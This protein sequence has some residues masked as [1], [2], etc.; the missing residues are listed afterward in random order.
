MTL[1]V[2]A[3]LAPLPG[4]NLRAEMPL[5]DTALLA[6]VLIALSEYSTWPDGYLSPGHEILLVGI[7]GD[8]KWKHL[9]EDLFR[10]RAGREI[11]V[12]RF[13]RVTDVPQCQIVF[14][15][16]S[17]AALI[18]PLLDQLHNVPVLTVSTAKGF[19]QLGGMVELTPTGRDI[20]LTL[21]LAAI[22]GGGLRISSRVIEIASLYEAPQ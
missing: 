20:D 7:F 6:R 13:S 4:Q 18:R 5:S 22:A 10:E 2:L 17:D 8:S 21:N 12:R 16:E 11:V 3:L 19:A 1:A 14:I 15:A 9:G